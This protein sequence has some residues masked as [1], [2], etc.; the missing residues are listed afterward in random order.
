MEASAIKLME[1][2]GVMDELVRARKAASMDDFPLVVM[3][4]SYPGDDAPRAAFYPGTAKVTVY[5]G[6]WRRPFTPA[7][8][9][10]AGVLQHELFHDALDRFRGNIFE[11]PIPVTDGFMGNLPY[12]LKGK[13]IQAV[14]KASVTWWEEM[15]VDVAAYRSNSPVYGSSEVLSKLIVPHAS[16]YSS[17]LGRYR[18][19]TKYEDALAIVENKLLKGDVLEGGRYEP[20]RVAFAHALS[21]ELGLGWEAN[22]EKALDSVD[23][24]SAVKVKGTILEL[25]QKYRSNKLITG[26]GTSYM[27]EADFIKA[28]SE[29]TPL[30]ESLQAGV[31]YP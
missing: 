15:W 10:K 9:L 22:I 3:F 2:P 13:D 11:M 12:W 20:E 24:G 21:A 31:T 4:R 17:E 28:S 23:A 8:S 7:E 16:V 26:A 30:Y 5:D 18:D 19:F 1:T 14:R 6:L 27:S 25:S 29:I